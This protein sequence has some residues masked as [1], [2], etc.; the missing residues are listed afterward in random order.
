MT[1][2]ELLLTL[3]SVRHIGLPC[4]A[5]KGGVGQQSTLSGW[6]NDGVLVGDVLALGEVAQQDLDRALALLLHHHGEQFAAVDVAV[7]QS[8]VPQAPPSLVA[9]VNDL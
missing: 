5:C 9:A 7:Q 1:T 6:Q 2:A 8:A 3:R 4:I